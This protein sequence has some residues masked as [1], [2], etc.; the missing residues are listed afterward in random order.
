MAEIQ[1]CT[2]Y[3][4]DHLMA[5]EVDKIQE[6]IKTRQMTKVPLAPDYV[7]GLINLR[8]QIVAAID[9]KKRMNLPQHETVVS[10]MNIVLQHHEGLI[11]LIVDSVGD[12]INVEDDQIEHDP[13]HLPD[14]LDKM[15]TGICKTDQFLLMVLDIDQVI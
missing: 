13:H 6:I 1:L 9:L 10:P 7:G 11:S 14:D 5:L 4:N 15:V 3:L 2:F 12:I 8:G